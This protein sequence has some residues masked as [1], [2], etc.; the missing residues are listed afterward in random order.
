MYFAEVSTRCKYAC[1][2]EDHAAKSLQLQSSGASAHPHPLHG[3]GITGLQLH[4]TEAG[5]PPPPFTHIQ[6]RPSTSG[7]WRISRHVVVIGKEGGRRREGLKTCLFPT[8]Q[9]RQS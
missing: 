8:P 3:F 6:L 7:R 9:I 5:A 1:I 2:L 4:R